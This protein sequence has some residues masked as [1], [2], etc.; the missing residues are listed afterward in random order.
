MDALHALREPRIELAPRPPIR[1]PP[2]RPM[3][4]E[5]AVGESVA[6]DRHREL[7]EDARRLR[8]LLLIRD[9]PPVRLDPAGG[10]GDDEADTAGHRQAHQRLEVPR[11]EPPVG[12][13][14]APRAQ[15][16]PAG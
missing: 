1:S 14:P 3:G 8:E 13:P 2:G 7:A 12:R 15:I 5:D 16:A 6:G 11:A 4:A 9:E 10:D